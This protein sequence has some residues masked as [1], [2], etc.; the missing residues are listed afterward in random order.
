MSHC[1]S[2]NGVPVG[3]VDVALLELAPEEVDGPPS[4]GDRILVEDVSI[5]CIPSRFAVEDPALP[6]T[7][8]AVPPDHRDL[9]SVGLLEDAAQ[10][11]R[12]VHTEQRLLECL[13]VLLTLQ[14]Y[15]QDH[16]VTIVCGTRG[17]D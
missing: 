8:S 14:G 6:D 2:R 12:T 11:H 10:N 3:A 13:R 15:F 9:W 17:G 4:D 16:L 5:P 7:V 1:C